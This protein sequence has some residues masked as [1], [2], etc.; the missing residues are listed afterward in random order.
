MPEDP[1]F[2]N[3]VEISTISSELLVGVPVQE[4]VSVLSRYHIPEYILMTSTVTK[5]LQSLEPAHMDPSKLTECLTDTRTNILNWVIDWATAPRTTQNVLWIHGLA[6]SGKST[7]AAT[8]ASAFRDQGRLGAFLFFARDVTERSNPTT[9]VR[10]LAYQLGTFHPDI[11]KC[12]ATYIKSTPSICLSPL[13]FQFRRLLIDPLSSFPTL[14]TPIVFVFDA[15]DQCGTPEERE[16]LMNVLSEQSGHLP[17]AIRFIFTSRAESDIR[18]A[19]DPQPPQPHILTR[20]LD[21]T[22]QANTDDISSYFRHGLSIVRAKNKRLSLG[23][24]WPGEETIRELTER[25]SGLFIWA[26]T[27][28][29]F[30]DGYN[31]KI[32]LDIILK[33]EVAPAAQAALDSLYKTALESEGNWDDKDFVTDFR[34]ILGLVLVAETPLS[35]SAIDRLLGKRTSCPADHTVSKLACVLQQTPTVRVLHSSFAEFLLTR[36]RCG[37]DIWW[38]NPAPHH[39]SLAVQ[40]LY[41]LNEVLKYNVCGLTLS[42]DVSYQGPSAN[43][44]FPEDV[45]YACMFWIEHI[46]IINDDVESIFE[47]LKSFLTRHLLHWFEAMSILRRSRDTI[48]SLRSLLI[49]MTVSCAMA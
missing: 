38:F 42:K 6:G 34:A 14:R 27:A 26:S 21:I 47:L 3:L 25:A 36:S 15:L 33:G 20:E 45:S 19:F 39:R 17:P 5:I 13:P 46:C 49:W 24:D 29:E 9:V 8:L 2:R 7:L 22:T 44:S 41:R 37:R 11:G 31:P 40:C 18:R 1:I 16:S 12:I 28:L 30:I 10:T 43:E 35:S 32:C 4:L 23:A 48:A